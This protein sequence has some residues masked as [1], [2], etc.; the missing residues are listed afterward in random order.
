[1]VNSIA[2]PIIRLVQRLSIFVTVVC[3]AYVI[4]F[5][6]FK[7]HDTFIPENTSDVPANGVVLPSPTPVFDLKHFDASVGAQAR[8]IFSMTTMGNPTGVVERP[9]KGQL[10]EH[11]KIVGILIG[12]PS[13]II[14]EDTL[15]GKTYFIDETSPQAGIKIVRVL[16]D[17][18]IINYQGQDIP[19]PVKK[20]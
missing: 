14:I 5:L 15:A 10:P 20:N 13:Q 9:A 1:M 6:F 2:W 16:Q 11:L 4:F 3:C 12:H 8:D 7:N 17:Q 19:V 18:M